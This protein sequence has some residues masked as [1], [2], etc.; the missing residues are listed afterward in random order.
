[1]VERKKT[2]SQ[3][4]LSA[5]GSPTSLTRLSDRT[6]SSHRKKKRMS[7]QVS[8]CSPYVSLSI[9]TAP[10]TD[11]LPLF[12]PAPF[13]LRQELPALWGKAHY[14][15]TFMREFLWKVF[16]GFPLLWTGQTQGCLLLF[17]P[18]LPKKKIKKISP[19]EGCKSHQSSQA[20]VKMRYFHFQECLKI[21][22]DLTR[23]FET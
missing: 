15:V 2:V 23:H 12:L 20:Q 6:K 7:S 11:H 17:I 10:K 22:R 5:P 3:S 16:S 13:L 9:R 1:M 8:K 21:T 18:W 4:A 19:A 14:T